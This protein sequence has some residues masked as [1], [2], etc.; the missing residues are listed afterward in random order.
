MSKRLS[1]AQRR[2]QAVVLLVVGAILTAGTMLRAGG[3]FLGF[4]LPTYYGTMAASGP[5]KLYLVGMPGPQEIRELHFLAVHSSDGIKWS[6]PVK[7]SGAE[8]AA[9]VADGWLFC[10]VQGPRGGRADVI[11]YRENQWKV[12]A[13]SF[14]WWPVGIGTCQGEL[15]VFGMDP[16]P[17]AQAETQTE[18]RTG[19]QTESGAIMT[20]TETESAPVGTGMTRVRSAVLRG[21]Q[22]VAGPS[23]QAP[24]GRPD[25]FHLLGDS[26]G[27]FLYWQVRL[28]NGSLGRQL[29]RASFD[30]KTLGPVES[31]DLGD[32]QTCV[33][34]AEPE[35]VVVLSQTIRGNWLTRR[36]LPGIHRFVIEDGKLTPQPDVEIPFFREHSLLPADFTAVR[37]ADKTWLLVCGEYYGKFLS[38]LYCMQLVDGQAVD[39]NPILARTTGQTQ[40]IVL[41]GVAAVAGVMLLAGAASGF[42]FSLFY[43]PGAMQGQGG[44]Y[45]TVVERAIAAGIDVVLVSLLPWLWLG[46]AMNE[47]LQAVVVS[48]VGLLV[49]GTVMESK[50]GQTVGKRLAGLQV[51]STTGRPPE[52]VE[53]FV[54]NLFKPFELFIFGVAVMMGTRRYQ[55]LGDLMARTV[56]VSSAAL[57]TNLFGPSGRDNDRRGESR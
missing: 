47:P 22:L 23:V 21:D 43:G 34:V 15:W 4:V 36:V 54:R 41:W 31:F 39:A 19:K 14:A 45:A 16:P 11:G 20:G 44:L 29:Y 56:V 1:P 26:H 50:G 6:E 12:L 57:K 46:Y 17:G 8:M 52:L 42:V 32:E 9:T 27:K 49:Y 37:F 2:G 33:L 3:S 48:A 10:V 55:R 30:G 24:D 7:R 28:P 40:E 38:G 13:N 18:V 51:L 25:N 5:E 53:A 35:R